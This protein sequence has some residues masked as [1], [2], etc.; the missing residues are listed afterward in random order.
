MASKLDC[1]PPEILVRIAGILDTAHP[2]SLL[3]FACANKGCYVIASVFL[4]RT[5]KITIDEGQQLAHDVKT[6]EMMLQRDDSFAHV[7]RL[8]LLCK[9]PGTRYRYISLDPCERM[10]DD[11]KLRGCWDL[12]RSES[13]LWPSNTGRIADMQRLR[14]PR[15]KRIYLW[16]N[17]SG[18]G[19][20]SDKCQRPQSVLREHI[21]LDG[22]ESPRSVPTDLVSTRT[23]G[24]MSALRVLK[25]Y[26]VVSPKSLPPP[27]IFTS[28]VTLTL[29]CST[30]ANSRSKQSWTYTAFFLRHLP[31]LA[32]LQLREWDRRQS[33]QPCLGSN[34]RTLELSTR[35]R[36]SIWEPLKDDILR[37]IAKCSPHLESLA[38][39]VRRSRGDAAEVARYRT[40]GRLPRLRHLDLTLDAA[41]PGFFYSWDANGVMTHYDTGIETWFD[42]QD[43]KYLDGNLHPLREG[44]ARDFL[45]NSAIDAALAR[46]I[47]E[48]IDGAKAKR[49][50]GLAPVS[51]ER[52]SLRVS[53]GSSFKERRAVNSPTGYVWPFLTAV[54]RTWLVERDVRDYARGVLH[55]HETR[56]WVRTSCLGIPRVEEEEKSPRWMAIWRRIWPNETEGRVWWD[57]WES[58][59]LALTPELPRN[60]DLTCL[61]SNSLE[62]FIVFDR[63]PLPIDVV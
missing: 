20:D 15:L 26:I 27:E 59:P 25:L 24:D 1:V 53:G 30:D 50:D 39:E 61:E 54:Q 62:E 35:R 14:P 9:S 22:P 5:I 60:G 28:L 7:R 47:F 37:H 33:I 58:F 10:E 31:R 2:A 46:S 32:T 6:L 8:I 40:L 56:P 41:P 45:V 18:I 49:P 36:S 52:L 48:V 13:H 38:V 51:L 23:F 42:E 17:S 29:T 19:W 34:L 4:Y 12:Y 16:K 11:L 3:A 44:H 63:E 57:D 43:K 55:V 21:Q